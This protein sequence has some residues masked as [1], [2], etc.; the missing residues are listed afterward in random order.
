MKNDTHK[1]LVPFSNSKPL[2]PGKGGG[3][4]H[5]R[6]ERDKQEL[7][8]EIADLAKVLR[9]LSEELIEDLLFLKDPNRKT[10]EA[11]QR[12]MSQIAG[13]LKRESA[14][15][16]SL[17][18]M[19]DLHPALQRI[20]LEK[21]ENPLDVGEQPAID[22]K[23]LDGPELTIEKQDKPTLFHVLSNRETE[24]LALL[25]A[26]YKPK[27]VAAKLGIAKG[28]VTVTLGHIKKKA[29]DLVGKKGTT[30]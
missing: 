22:L 17:F 15:L 8:N 9:R 23:M 14:T 24:I 2:V 29:R 28:T 7:R 21:T 27:D 10:P 3:L 13:A 18:E 30:P 26:D 16:S 11:I 25:L 5:W 12:R 1:D 4:P 19:A 6:L 20:F